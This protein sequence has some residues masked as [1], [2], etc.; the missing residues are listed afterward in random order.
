[1]QNIHRIGLNR[2]GKSVVG[3]EYQAKGQQKK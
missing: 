3:D 1:M 2:L